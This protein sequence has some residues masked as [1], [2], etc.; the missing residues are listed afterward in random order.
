[1]A[2]KTIKKAFEEKHQAGK[3]QWFF[4]KLNF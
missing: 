3:N 2:K 4:T 1:E